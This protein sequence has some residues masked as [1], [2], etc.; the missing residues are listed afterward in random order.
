MKNVVILNF[1]YNR[2]NLWHNCIFPIRYVHYWLIIPKMS[3]KMSFWTTGLFHLLKCTSAD[4]CAP[5][6]GLTDCLTVMLVKEIWSFPRDNSRQIIT[7]HE[8]RLSVNFHYVALFFTW[9]SSVS[10]K[11]MTTMSCHNTLNKRLVY[12]Q[13][14]VWLKQIIMEGHEG[15]WEFE[16]DQ[17][18]PDWMIFEIS[19]QHYFY[20]SSPNI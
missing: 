11:A 20:K 16:S 12:L 17:W 2:F 15:G 8:T 9:I 7:K 5:P 14:F 4:H 13:Q 6:A 10:H 1:N 18:E 19:W 3:F